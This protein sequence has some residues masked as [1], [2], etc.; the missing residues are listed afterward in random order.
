M[1]FPNLSNSVLHFGQVVPPKSACLLF[2]GILT[3]ACLVSQIGQITLLV[4]IA[5]ESG[6]TFLRIK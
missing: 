2:L 1:I 3:M 6:F 4:F 5:T